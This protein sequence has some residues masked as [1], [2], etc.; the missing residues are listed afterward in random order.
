M[1]DGREDDPAPDHAAVLA[2]A[3]GWPPSV[4][5]AVAATPP[6]R[7][8]PFAIR[9]APA[10]RRLGMGR[11]VRVGDAAHAMEPDLGQG[12]CQALE[13]VAALGAVAAL[14][15]D[16]MLAAFE[17]LRLA[18]VRT[19][20][21]RSAGGS[22]GAHASWPVRTAVRALLRAVPDAVAGSIAAA[23]HAMPDYARLATDRAVTKA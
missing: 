11:I 8:I 6:G 1:R 22:A 3:R 12:A 16:R 19:L 9:A 20:V 18:R 15:P 10:P 17:R 23:M 2:R 21:R 4:A 14:P 7:L 5:E 13:D